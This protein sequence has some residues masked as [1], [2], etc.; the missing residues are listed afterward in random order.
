VFL[1]VGG[2]GGHVTRARGR[3]AI[4]E[5]TT[6]SPPVSAQEDRPVPGSHSHCGDQYREKWGRLANS[7]CCSPPA[8]HAWSVQQEL[9]CATLPHSPGPA[10]LS[11]KAPV[12]SLCAGL[13]VAPLNAKK[14]APLLP[15]WVSFQTSRLLRFWVRPV[16]LG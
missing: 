9:L 14:D 3:P 10:A 1:S 12:M 11:A 7:L 4:N 15:S 16:R 2:H 6:F 8:Q 13:G 5:I